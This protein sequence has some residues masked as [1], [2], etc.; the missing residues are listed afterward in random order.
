MIFFRKFLKVRSLFEVRSH[1]CIVHQWRRKALVTSLVIVCREHT[2]KEQRGDSRPRASKER[3]SSWGRNWWTRPRTR[4]DDPERLRDFVFAQPFQPGSEAEV[5]LSVPPIER[6]LFLQ[7]RGRGIHNYIIIN[8]N[9]IYERPAIFACPPGSGRFY[10][11]AF[12]LIEVAYDWPRRVP[13]WLFLDVSLPRN[14]RR[15]SRER[16]NVRAKE[17]RETLIPREGILPREGPP[18]QRAEFIT[19]ISWRRGSAVLIGL[20]SVVR[21]GPG[22][23]SR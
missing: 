2:G 9:D 10:G 6:I 19:V 21:S 17:E 7:E 4:S 15:A 16:D 1:R 20:M 23:D 14:P 3:D 12:V 18:C 22:S 8:C 5:K 13:S 11:L